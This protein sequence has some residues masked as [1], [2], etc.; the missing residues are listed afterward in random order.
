VN[1]LTA[2]EIESR[3]IMMEMLD[4]YR[5]KVPGFETARIMQTAPQLGVRHSRRLQGIKKMTVDDWTA[6]KTHEDEIGISPPP[7]SKHPN[8]SIPLLCLVPKRIHN[9]MA[10]GRN[11]SCDARTHDF[12]RE[13]PNCWVMGQGAGTAAAVALESGSTVQDVHLPEVRRQLRSQDVYLQDLE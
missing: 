11:L 6:G 1:D 5:R 10:A 2:V 3:R 13:I 12:M 8:V 9:L 7:S 4:F